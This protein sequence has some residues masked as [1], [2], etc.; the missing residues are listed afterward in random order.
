MAIDAPVN[1][2]PDS[3]LQDTAFIPHGIASMLIGSA[4]KQVPR[5]IVVLNPKGGSGKTTIA[6]NLAAYFA[7]NGFST[8]LIDE[9]PQGSSLRWLNKRPD[10]CPLI[11]GVSM[12]NY[13]GKVTRTFATRLPHR[14]QRIVV[15]TPAAL[16]KTAFSRHDA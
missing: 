11:Y 2:T 1:I 5:R 9:D 4:G 12:Y 7:C 8:V 3:L 10:E 14:T 13:P 16:T 6:T 15:D